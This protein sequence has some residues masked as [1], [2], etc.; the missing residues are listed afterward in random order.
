MIAYRYT[1]GVNFQDTEV[2]KSTERLATLK[3]WEEPVDNGLLMSL[4]LILLM[5]QV[6]LGR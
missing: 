2:I 5:G 3:V 6:R 1:F 4:V